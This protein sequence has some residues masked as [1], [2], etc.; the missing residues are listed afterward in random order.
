MSERYDVIGIGNAI[1]DVLARAEDNFLVKH[2]ILK[3]PAPDAGILEGVTR[4]AVMELA[5]AAGIPVQEPALTRHDVYTA[6]ECF[7]TGTAAEV[8]PVVKCDGRPIGTGQ[9]GPITQ[10]LRA[11]FLPPDRDSEVSR[12]FDLI[13]SREGVEV[14]QLAAR[15][16]C[17][18]TTPRGGVTIEPRTG[19]P[20]V[21]EKITGVSTT[22]AEQPQRHVAGRGSR[23]RGPHSGPAVDSG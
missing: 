15:P 21:A 16:R 12:V 9:P 13:F 5:R 6:D 17:S 10:D 2:G 11:R 8:I 14:I 22:R 18:A 19:Y 1:V 7:L 20:A 3:T 4:A 23:D